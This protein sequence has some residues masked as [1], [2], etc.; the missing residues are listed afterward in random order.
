MIQDL[1]YAIRSLRKSPGFTVATVLTLALGIGANTAIFSVVNA[2][3]LRPLPFK[4]ADRLVQVWGTSPGSKRDFVS[5]PDLDDWRAM[6]RSFSG[7]AASSPQSV[8]LTGGDEPERVIG[9]F[10]SADFFPV[11]DVQPALGR[12]FLPGEDRPGA[13]RVAVLTDSLWHNRFGGD[14]AIVGKS[15]N[16]N[17]EPYTVAGILPPGFVF[18]PWDADVYLPIY[19]HPNFTLDRAAPVTGVF[20]RLAPGVSPT[21][22]QAEITAVAARLASAYPA[23][24]QNRGAMVVPLKEIVVA[25]ARPIVLAL[26]GAVAFVLLIGCAN[27]AGLLMTRM[28]GRERERAVRLALGA[29]RGNL[30]AHVLAEALV[31]ALA[32]GVIGLIAGIWGLEALSKAAADYLPPS[33]KLSLNG[34]VTAFTLGVSLITALLVAAM[35]AWQGSSA[36]P[37]LRDGRGAGS[38]ATR[39]RARNLLVVGEVA[40]ALVVASGRRTDHQEP[41][42]TG[43]DQSRLRRSQS[44]DAGVPAAARKVHQQCHA[45]PV[46]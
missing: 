4:D 14:P 24:N 13:E 11:L 1:R 37:S 17:G 35:P 23:S 20:A 15:L 19:K 44:V 7:L 38:G 6:T 34:T 46:S 41:A 12:L 10:V 21:Q 39:N 2:V 18:A 26:A 5:Q 42:G 22:A 8:N 29:S 33:T 43:A 28:V 40:L 16:F 32:G 36:Q 30:I 27:V 9:D 3:L 45:N 31:I 25:D